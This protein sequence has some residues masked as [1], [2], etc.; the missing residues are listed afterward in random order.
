[1]SSAPEAMLELQLKS[2]KVAYEREYQAIPDRKY[3]FDFYCHT[4]GM[5]TFTGK[6]VLVEV[7][8]GQWAAR[9]GSRSA[10]VGGYGMERDCE[11]ASLAAVHG[12]RLIQVTPS[13]IRSGKA[14]QWIEKALALVS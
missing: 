1:M 6:V 10:H 5:P 12:Y 14:L 7:Q 4:N 11:K 13:Q 3:R 9:N 8:G 2:A